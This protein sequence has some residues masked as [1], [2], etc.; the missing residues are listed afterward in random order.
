[1]SLFPSTTP[2]LPPPF[3]Q[4]LNPRLEQSKQVRRKLSAT[5][6]GGHPHI[7]ELRFDKGHRYPRPTSMTNLPRTQPELPP[8]DAVLATSPWSYGNPLDLHL[9]RPDSDSSLA[10]LHP[11]RRRAAPTLWRRD[12]NP[13]AAFNWLIVPGDPLDLKSIL[14]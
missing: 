3:P 10:S 5:G 6:P 1:M 13:E 11:I 7:Q 12:E 4:S 9:H 2:K 14:R 8:A